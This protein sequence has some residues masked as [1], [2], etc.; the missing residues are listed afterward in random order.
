MCLQNDDGLLPWQSPSCSCHGGTKLCAHETQAGCKC[1]THTCHSRYLR[2]QPGASCRLDSMPIQATYV[3]TSMQQPMN[4]YSNQQAQ[5][6]PCINLAHHADQISSMPVNKLATTG[7]A[8]PVQMEPQSL[9]QVWG[10][11]GT[12][13]AHSREHT[14]GH[15]VA[16]AVG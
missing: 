3:E 7:L 13:S 10:G 4:W 16:A 15:L 1:L 11:S 9:M 12:F 5:L 14:S 8:V 6:R 2:V